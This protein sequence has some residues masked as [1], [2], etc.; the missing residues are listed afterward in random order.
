MIKSFHVFPIS[1][2][3]LSLAVNEVSRKEQI[4]TIITIDTMEGKGFAHFFIV[5]CR[6]SVRRV[7]SRLNGKTFHNMFLMENFL[8]KRDRHGL[9]D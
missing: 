6:S 1:S 9:T 5:F 3:H 8:L 7:F 4:I 2:M